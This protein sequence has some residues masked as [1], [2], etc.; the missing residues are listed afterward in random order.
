MKRANVT[1]RDGSIYQTYMGYVSYIPDVQVA[2]AKL[3]NAVFGSFIFSTIGAAAFAW[4]FIPWAQE[5]GESILADHHERGV[6]IVEYDVLKMMLDRH[7]LHQFRERAKEECP[8]LT[9]AQV[10]ALPLAQRK[11]AGV[12]LP[13]KIATLPFPYGFEQSHV[14][15]TGTTG[16]GRRRS[17]VSSWRRRSNGVIDAS[18]ST[19]PGTICLPS[20][21]PS[22]TLF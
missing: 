12:L 10:E 1:L 4:W 8:D 3:L 21:T 19:L 5:R 13:Y 18:C 22:A 2:W 15:L 20:T 17:S 11:A 14:M 16:T 9:L 6:E 7:N